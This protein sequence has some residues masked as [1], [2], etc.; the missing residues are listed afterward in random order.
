[1]L[2]GSAIKAAN[3][4]SVGRRRT[5]DPIP[6]RGVAVLVKESDDDEGDESPD[7]EVK[8]NCRGKLEFHKTFV[9][10]SDD[11][12]DNE[13]NVHANDLMT[14]DEDD[15][16]PLVQVGKEYL[17]DSKF[18]KIKNLKQQI[19]AEKEK[20]QVAESKLAKVRATIDQAKSIPT[21]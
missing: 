20:R 6:R 21:K 4:F 17:S 1:M 15:D 16:V 9:A 11:D 18:E 10:D 7:D 5:L 19:E 2:A 3:F 8:K 12:A 13:D 14:D